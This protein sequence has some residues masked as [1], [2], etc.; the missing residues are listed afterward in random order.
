[1]RLPQLSWNE[2]QV[3][4]I[5]SLFNQRSD[6]NTGYPINIWQLHLVSHNLNTL[7]Y[8]EFW[9]LE[10]HW[11]YMIFLWWTQNDV[12]F[13][14]I[15][16]FGSSR[17]TITSLLITNFCIGLHNITFYPLWSTLVSSHYAFHRNVNAKKF[18]FDCLRNFVVFFGV[19]DSKP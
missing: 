15:N 1:M 18:N 2:L 13:N 6:W 17:W 12:E 19:C 7:K 11:F 14:E 9:Y 16:A 5:L 3:I 10:L 8:C 4:P